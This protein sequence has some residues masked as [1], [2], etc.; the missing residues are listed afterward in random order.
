MDDHPFYQIYELMD[1]EPRPAAA[2]AFES[3]AD[4]FQ[5]GPDQNLLDQDH[6]S[7]NRFIPATNDSQID[8]I[9]QL[10]DTESFVFSYRGLLPQ[11][12]SHGQQELGSAEPQY[13]SVTQP[14]D[15]SI[16]SCTNPATE[17]NEVDS[18][19]KD[20]KNSYASQPVTPPPHPIHDSQ[21]FTMPVDVLS[22]DP[23]P[24]SI[25]N[26]W[27][28]KFSAW[29]EFKHT[30]SITIEPATVQYFSFVPL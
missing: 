16:T 8:A 22:S 1:D 24:R 15:E 6:T 26:L 28:R 19:L 10:N 17:D 2:S 7:G 4:G 3:S 27:T 20:F 21:A 25:P 12:S 30:R 29:N 14:L 11:C 23:P 9:H 18:I 13:N 5:H